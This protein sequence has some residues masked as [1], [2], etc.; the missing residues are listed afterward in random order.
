MPIL[1]AATVDRLIVRLLDANYAAVDPT[2]ANVFFLT[3]DYVL[4]PDKLVERVCILLFFCFLYLKRIEISFLFY[5]IKKKNN[6]I[7]DQ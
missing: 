5:F 3:H 4:T 2:F 7:A 1:S 6:Q